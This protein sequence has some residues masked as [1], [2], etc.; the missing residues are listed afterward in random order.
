MVLIAV[1]P[2]LRAGAA[3]FCLFTYLEDRSEILLELS[4]HDVTLRVAPW[5]SIG[6]PFRN[7]SAAERR[8]RVG[9]PFKAGGDSRHECLGFGGEPKQEQSCDY[10]YVHRFVDS[11]HGLAPSLA[12]PVLSPVNTLV[13]VSSAPPLAA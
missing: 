13:T 2:Y 7:S 6:C 5:M 8:M 4:L 1:C 3:A 11:G 10:T 9:R 12:T